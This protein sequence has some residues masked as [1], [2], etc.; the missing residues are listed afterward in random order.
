MK[1]N[2]AMGVIPLK[3]ILFFLIG[4]AIIS[5]IICL[6]G[7]DFGGLIFNDRWLAWLSAVAV[8]ISVIWFGSTNHPHRLVVAA[9]II[10]NTV[11]LTVLLTFNTLP[12]SDYWHVYDTAK[13]MAEGNLDIN[14]LPENHYLNLNTWQ[15]GVSWFVSLIFRIIGPSFTALK[16]L[17]LILINL[18]LYTLYRIAKST[19]GER[20]ASAI[21]LFAGCFY[22]V[23]VTVGQFSNQNL[24]ALLLL[25]FIALLN[26]KKFF[27]AGLLLPVI[28]FIRAVGIVC[29]IAFVV[30]R[31]F[32]W[33]NKQIDLK[34]TLRN[35]AAFLIP[36][37]ILTAAIDY[38]CVRAGYAREAVS[39][40]PYPYYKFYV[41]LDYKGDYLLQSNEQLIE[42]KGTV[43]E[44]NQL[45]KE[46]LVKA[47]TQDIGS[48]LANN[49]IKSVMFLGYLD[50]KFTNVYNHTFPVIPN[51]VVSL[52]VA[53]GWGEYLILLLLCF[54]GIA[55]Y[56]RRQG[57]DYLQILLI[58]MIG[59]HFFVEAWPD[60]RYDIYF[61]M[62]ILASDGVNVIVNRCRAYG[63][64]RGHSLINAFKHLPKLGK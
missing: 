57:I 24:E 15:I 61:L 39:R 52:C 5:C 60:Y 8:F 9:F 46:A 26:N 7:L 34:T 49:T 1:A 4:F 21:T 2:S 10:A 35:L 48:T 18:T 22:P 32:L 47:Y 23:L 25:C 41:G 64:I 56:C 38:A 6:C 50:W 36:F 45:Q 54:A 29:L 44:Y 42:W 43:A 51:K 11:M 28:S 14:A 13:L 63:G 62:L 30:Y 40:T 20:G 27:W 16:I 33:L 37:L 55:S 12:V 53:V 17:N 58:G 19:A 3:Y 31:L 59:V